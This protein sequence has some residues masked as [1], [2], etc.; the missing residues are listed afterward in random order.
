MANIIIVNMDKRLNILEGIEKGTSPSYLGDF[1]K[2]VNL[3]IDSVPGVALPTATL[4][5][6]YPNSTSNLYSGFAFTVDATDNTLTG[7]VQNL[8]NAYSFGQSVR[9]TTTGTLPAGLA[10]ATT[11]YV[12]WTTNTGPIKLATTFKNLEDGVYVD[13]TDTGTGTHTITAE[14]MGAVYEIYPLI[15]TGSYYNRVL[16]DDSNQ[17]WV[18]RTFNGSW[19][20]LTGMGSGAI[21]S[22]A[23]WKNYIL[24]FHNQAVDAFGPVNGTWSTGSWTNSFATLESDTTSHPSILMSND[25][26]YIGGGNYVA[27]LEQVTGETFDPS[28]T[29]TFTFNAQALDLP[30]NE[31]IYALDEL[32]SQL[33]IGTGNGRS[34]QIY[35]WDTFSPSFS[36]VVKTAIPYVATMK[37]VNNTLYFFDNNW[38]TI[39]AT[40]G[41]SVQKIKEFS[42][43]SVNIQ[44][45][46]N[47]NPL[48]IFART[49]A[50]MVI[51]DKI[52]FGVG[53]GVSADVTPGIYSFNLLNGALTLENTCAS[54]NITSVVNFYALY[55]V[56]P[57][58]F[59]A[60]IY[61]ASFSSDYRY[62]LESTYVSSYYRNATSF[63][64][65]GLI[66]VGTKY[67]PT[68]YRFF[69]IQLGKEMSTGQTI[70]L[71]YRNN[72]TD[73]WT[74]IGTMSYANDGAIASKI[75][76]NSSVS[77]DQIQFKCLI[78]CSSTA[79]VAPEIKAIYIY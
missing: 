31:K 43:S 74:T 1:N 39:Y 23:V 32:N 36:D 44:Q 69:E 7:T 75:I 21:R 8:Y 22:I 49:H 41:V 51:K 16:L 52:F 61:D 20:K 50:L 13:I 62:R 78:T 25:V 38:G 45:S 12:G 29:D 40:N 33:A 10:T 15:V 17:V 46:I 70:T 68:T 3:D 67:Q 54:G 76:E 72:L 71:Y 55:S 19:M 24:V 30:T 53:S 64:E 9:L 77:G 59:Y 60:S 56:S 14:K 35:F 4:Q 2:I 37:V 18:S 79:T 6:H 63:F 57:L 47:E 58:L 27:S 11:Y 42:E 26:L 65:T 34:G 5:N 48:S 28:D 66:T 73:S